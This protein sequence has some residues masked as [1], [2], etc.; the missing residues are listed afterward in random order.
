MENLTF[1]QKLSLLGQRPEL[2]RTFT[3]HQKEQYLMNLSGLSFET[4]KHAS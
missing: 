4:H 3:R 1:N 2:F